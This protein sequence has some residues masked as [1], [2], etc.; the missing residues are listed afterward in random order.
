MQNV[1][2]TLNIF[3][4]FINMILITQKGENKL[5]IGEMELKETKCIGE[6]VNLL[7]PKIM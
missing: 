1:V 3:P 6:D 2:V 5:I 4:F 7:S